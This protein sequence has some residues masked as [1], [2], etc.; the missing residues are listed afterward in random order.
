MLESN[1][2]IFK[3]SVT[4]L[5]KIHHWRQQLEERIAKQ[6]L[7][8][9]RLRK[10][11]TKA[12]NSS[13][14]RGEPCAYYGA[15]GGAYD[16]IFQPTPNSL[17]F[18]VKNNV[19]GDEIDLTDFDAVG[20]VIVGVISDTEYTTLLEWQQSIEQKLGCIGSY[21]YKFSGTTL[22]TIIKVRCVETSEEIDCTDY[23]W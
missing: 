13:L 12:I 3:A 2:L 18:K 22:G 16:N 10:F 14:E 15:I 6:Q 5:K 9:G 4:Q 20:D 7:E 21:I 17:I 19:S 11:A 23:D 8:T 1:Q